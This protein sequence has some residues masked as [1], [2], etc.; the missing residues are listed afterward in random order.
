[1]TEHGDIGG[2]FESVSFRATPMRMYAY[3][4][5]GLQKDEKKAVAL[6][7]Q[8]CDGCTIYTRLTDTSKE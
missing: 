3:G 5:E 4:K 6:F 2:A 8:A 1:M 7:R